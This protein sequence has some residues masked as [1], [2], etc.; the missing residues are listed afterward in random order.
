MLR[1]LRRRWWVVLLTTVIAGVAAYAVASL[2]SATYSAEGVAV[3]TANR[4][5]TPDQANGLAV[6]D[7][8]LIPKDAAITASVARSLGTTTKDVR[9]R[10]SVFNDP[11]TAVL[12]IDYEGR[13][14]GEA[15]AGA[16]A[17]LHGIAGSHPVSPNIAR[18][19]IHVVRFPTPPAPSR[20]VPTLVA[21]G[22]ILGLALGA[23]LLVAWERTDP[24]IDDLDDLG[25][26]AAAPAT[27]LDSM[28]DPATA[29]LLE[30]WRE[31]AGQSPAS[32]ALVPAS[33]RL[34][35]SLGDVARA[36]AL[37][38]EAVNVVPG[39]GSQS[40]LPTRGETSLVVGGVPGGRLAGEGV[41]LACNLTVL[42]VER[43]TRRVD[44][45]RAL[46]VLHRFGIHPAWAILISRASLAHARDRAKAGTG[47]SKVESVGSHLR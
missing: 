32:V 7:A 44:V 38:D 40:S 31:L 12:R 34:E 8:V 19:S 45:R 27:S 2:R 29:V 22:I 5:L 10:L 37:A 1:A 42:V 43:G 35:P 36:L 39:N 18:N 23:L 21:I 28:S 16:T 33:E 30:R 41:A 47:Q 25:A 46:E 20:G 24:R 4:V 15:Q 14:A 17:A 13:S 9:S 6:T 26:A 11:A 3:V